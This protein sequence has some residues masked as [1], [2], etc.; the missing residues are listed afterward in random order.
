MTNSLSRICP[1]CGKILIYKNKYN[2]N[3]AEACNKCCFQCSMKIRKSYS[4]ENNPFYG[5]THSIKT[6]Q[7]IGVAN[8]YERTEAQKEQAR[9]Q[10]SL[11]TNK[12]SVLL[13]WEEKYGKEQA[14]VLWEQKREKNRI[15]SSGSNNPMFGKP[16]PQGSGN[17]WSGW[18]K[19]WYFRSLLELSFMINV[20]ERFKFIWS[21]GEK[22]KI[23]YFDPLGKQRNYFP[24]FLLNNK[25]LVEIK[26]NKLKYTPL[27]MS[28][29][30]AAIEYCLS[31]G[32]VYKTITPKKLTTTQI[33][34]LYKNKT[35]VFLPKYEKLL[36]EKYL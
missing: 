19:G 15:A 7:K 20:I 23:P 27:V 3:K 36:K 30:Q 2:K 6:K 21:N 4:G 24:D 34:E 14:L 11:V 1:I 29:K 8:S 25:Y 28:K 26:P 18:Y 16:S 10:L 31:K 32:L 35:L 13:C 33:V 12:K 9:T 5:K 17:G 22:I